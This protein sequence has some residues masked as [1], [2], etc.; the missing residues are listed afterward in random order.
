A[1]IALVSTIATSVPDY[2]KTGRLFGTVWH[3]EFDSLGLHP[4]WPFGNLRQVYD[5]ADVVPHGLQNGL[6]DQNA[7]CVFWSTYPP[8]VARQLTDEGIGRLLLGGDYEK[9]L[10]SAFLNVVLSYPRQV[11]ELHVYYKSAMILQTLR[12]AIGFD[13]SAQRVKILVLAALQFIV[14]VLF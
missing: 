6:R 5:C 14:F 8:A 11:L 7:H 2:V 1:S 4:D 9:V 3:R 12:N 10:R 13:L